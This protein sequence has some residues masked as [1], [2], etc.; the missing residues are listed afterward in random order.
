MEQELLKAGW[1]KR[2]APINPDDP[3]SE[4]E[5][6]WFHPKV[7]IQADRQ[8]LSED[9]RIEVASLQRAHTLDEAIRIFELEKTHRQARELAQEAIA[10]TKGD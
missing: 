10:E 7:K 8:F 6:R 4:K 2:K 5:E 1:K 3:D 9:D